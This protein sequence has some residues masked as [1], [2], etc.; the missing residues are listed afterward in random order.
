MY[1]SVNTS[2]K[3]D[4]N[5]K[6]ILDL[7]KTRSEKAIDETSKKYGKYCHFIAFNILR[8]NEDS[9]ECVN[10]TY[11]Q[12]WNSIPPHLPTI[13]S[14]YLGKITRNLAINKYKYYTAQKRGAGEYNAILEELNDCISPLHNPEQVVSRQ[15]LIDILNH[16]LASQKEHEQ[17]IF[18]QRYWYFLSIKE[19]S[20]N[21]RFSESKV[22]M[23]LM[24]DRNELREILEKEGFML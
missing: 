1:F 10:D 3:V 21:L 13:L 17:K 9:E 19:I 24:R 12:A 20:S 23:I 15:T 6:Q 2:Y 22:K 18:V 4:M 5:D 11:L 16:F 7:Y 8:S 14:S